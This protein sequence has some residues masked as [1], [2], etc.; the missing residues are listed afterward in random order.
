MMNEFLMIPHKPWAIYLLGHFPYK[1]PNLLFKPLLL[2]HQQLNAIPN[3]YTPSEGVCKDK[4]KYS[5]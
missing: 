1:K 3:W 2:L 5:M 4:I